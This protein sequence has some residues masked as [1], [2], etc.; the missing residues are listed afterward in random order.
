[1]SSSSLTDTTALLRAA[2]PPSLSSLLFRPIKRLAF[3]SA[4]VLPFL[5]LSLLVGGLDSQSMTLAFITL[6]ALNAVALYVG[7]PHGRE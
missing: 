5:H 1:M 3:W 2:S 4:I 6:L 7:H